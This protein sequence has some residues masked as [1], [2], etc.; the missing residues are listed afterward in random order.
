MER[1]AQKGPADPQVLA[2][3]KGFWS[4]VKKRLAEAHATMMVLA[5]HKVQPVQACA[6]HMA[7]LALH[8]GRRTTRRV[9]KHWPANKADHLCP[10]MVVASCLHE[11][12]VYQSQMTLLRKRGGHG[13]NAHGRASIKSIN[14]MMVMHGI[15]LLIPVCLTSSQ[16]PNSFKPEPLLLL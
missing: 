4:E 7:C 12:V 13:V 5:L 14:L 3:L 11:H 15:C 9:E 6:T 2:E 10:I 16:L 8:A 1:W